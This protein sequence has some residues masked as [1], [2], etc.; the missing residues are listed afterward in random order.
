[1]HKFLQTSTY[2]PRIANKD[3]DNGNDSNEDE[4]GYDGNEDPSDDSD[5]LQHELFG[6]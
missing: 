3:G 6:N 2:L 5:L 4:E 1:M